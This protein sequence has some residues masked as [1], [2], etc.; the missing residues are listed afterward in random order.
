MI[1]VLAMPMAAT[2]NA[3]APM[4]PR[5]SCTRRDA[6][7][8]SLRMSS[9]DSVWNPIELMVLCTCSTCEMSDTFTNAVPYL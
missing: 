3:T 4:P 9:L 5:I 6:C 2:R 1:I 8:I 7:S